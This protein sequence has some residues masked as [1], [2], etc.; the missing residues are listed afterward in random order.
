MATT[1]T[2]TDTITD[3]SVTGDSESITRHMLA[4]WYEDAPDEIYQAVRD[5]ETALDRHEPTG[6]RVPHHPQRRGGR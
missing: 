1:Y 6:C 5:L 3:Q 2:V 4:A